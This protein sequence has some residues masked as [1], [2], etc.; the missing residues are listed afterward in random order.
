LI[1]VNA[2]GTPA[3]LDGVRQ[4]NRRIGTMDAMKERTAAPAHGSA[5]QSDKPAG[6]EQ[7]WLQDAIED[8]EVREAL[9]VRHQHKPTQEAG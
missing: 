8:D 1:P 6:A 4:P 2:T 9:R 5:Q 7:R 3:W